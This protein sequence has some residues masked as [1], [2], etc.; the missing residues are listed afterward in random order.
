MVVV[1]GI[2]INNIIVSNSDG[3]N[4]NH[5]NNTASTDFQASHNTHIHTQNTY[6]H[7]EHTHT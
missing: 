6:I 2:V 5:N 3:E 7:T 1:S 4:H